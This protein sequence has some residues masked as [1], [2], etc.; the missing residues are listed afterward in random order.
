MVH[1][2]VAYQKIFLKLT[3]IRSTCNKEDKVWF[4]EGQYRTIYIKHNWRFTLN[5]ELN[6]GKFMHKLVNTK[7]PLPVSV[8]N[9]E[10]P[11]PTNQ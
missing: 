1:G 8:V 7:V 5:R 10:N 6:L 9:G 4:E 2:N 11:I 3:F